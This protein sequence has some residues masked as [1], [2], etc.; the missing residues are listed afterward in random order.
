GSAIPAQA[1]R[2]IKLSENDFGLLS[3]DPAFKNTAA[4][5][6]SVTFIDGDRGILRYRGIPIEEVAEKSNYLEA[7]YLTLFGELPSEEQLATWTHHITHHTFTHENLKK[8]ID[9]FHHD[10]H[11]MGMFVS[12]VAALSTFYPEA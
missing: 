3:Y 4:C 2:Q 10:A 5:K 8:M 11:P 1:L 7:A 9:G 12:T 6:S